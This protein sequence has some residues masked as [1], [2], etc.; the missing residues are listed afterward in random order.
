MEN[1]VLSDNR[2]LLAVIGVGWSALLALLRRAIA[3]VEGKIDDNARSVA[4][5]KS[6]M[7][8]SMGE[9]KYR[10]E[11]SLR[12]L[13][14]DYRAELKDLSNRMDTAMEA[15]R[16]ELE[17]ISRHQAASDSATRKA[18]EE[19]IENERRHLVTR[20]EFNLLAANLQGMVEAIY[21]HVI[22]HGVKN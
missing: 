11:R 13:L 22:S 7:G 14:D 17:R 9:T 19:R 21:N 16:A 3:Q 2:F 18:L 20:H 5:L 6:Q 4:E 10:I 8:A 1:Y 15:R 12:D